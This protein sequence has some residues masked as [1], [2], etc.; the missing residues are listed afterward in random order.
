MRF[1]NA[2]KA[3]LDFV[4]STLELIVKHPVFWLLLIAFM[5]YGIAQSPPPPG[6]EMCPT[7]QQL[8]RR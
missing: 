5:I 3:V 8:I 1:Q 4:W 6:P 7:C 2:L